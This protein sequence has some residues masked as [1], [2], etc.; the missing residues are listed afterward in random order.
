MS[1]V[2]RH[3]AARSIDAIVFITA[4]QKRPRPLSMVRKLCH[5]DYKDVNSGTGLAGLVAPAVLAA[6]SLTGVKEDRRQRRPAGRPPALPGKKG[7]RVVMFCRLSK[8]LR[9]TWPSRDRCRW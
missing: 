6:G 9:G 5:P 8:T 4:S 1:P 7:R 2:A 3:A